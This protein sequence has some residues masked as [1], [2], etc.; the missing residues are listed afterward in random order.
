MNDVADHH[1]MQDRTGRR[2]RDIEKPP[3]KRRRWRAA[4]GAGGCSR[5]ARFCCSPAASPWARGATMRGSSE[6]DGDCRAAARFRAD[7][8]RGDGTAEPGITLV[9]LP[10]TT[11]AFAAA[12]MYARASGYIE[13]RNVDI[14]DRVKAGDLLVADPAPELDH[15][16][17]RTRRRWLRPKP[18]LHAGA[19]QPGAG[20]GDLGSRPPWSGKAGSTQQQGTIDV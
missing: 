19:G 9:T 7:S 6:V 4:D 17:A 18:T 1:M 14:G 5:S 16:I 11:L 2:C 8:A 20:A 10:A 13:K 12:N 3:A 15:Q